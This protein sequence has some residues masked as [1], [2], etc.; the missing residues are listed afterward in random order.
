MAVCYGPFSHRVPRVWF[1]LQRVRLLPT[2]LHFATKNDFFKFCALP[3][4]EGGGFHRLSGP[5][6]LFADDVVLLASPRSDLQLVLWWFGAEWKVA[7][8]KISRQPWS[9]AAPSQ[10]VPQGLVYK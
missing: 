1:T 4:G 8:M 2:R 5:L 7:G 10:G 3:G 6:L 9:S